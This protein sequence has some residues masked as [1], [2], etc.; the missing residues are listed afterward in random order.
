MYLLIDAENC[1]DKIRIKDNFNLAIPKNQKPSNINI[2]EIMFD[3]IHSNNNYIEIFITD[4]GCWKIN[5]FRLG[6]IENNHIESIC[7]LGNPNELI[8]GGE[9]FVATGTNQNLAEDFAHI[10]AKF[11]VPST[12]F[13]SLRNTGN[14]VGLWFKD[15]DLLDSVSYHENLHHANI[16][17]TKGIALEKKDNGKWSSATWAQKGTP[18]FKNSGEFTQLNT[19]FDAIQISSLIVPQI[20][21]L[22]DLII[23]LGTLDADYVLSLNLWTAN[24]LLLQNL[25][26]QFPIQSNEK[27]VIN[28]LVYPP[29]IYILQVE[30]INIETAEKSNFKKSITF[31]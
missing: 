27:L 6:T 20:A 5:D 19:I 23:E 24:G 10:N 22:Q 18:T 11:I 7:M 14:T 16:K 30:I 31:N 2:N 15:S 8:C 3:A 9:Y 25:Y 13:I 29:G 26:N 17:N 1:N 4:T 28:N 12:S 21:Q